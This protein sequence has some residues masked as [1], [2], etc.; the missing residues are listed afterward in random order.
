[1]AD[2]FFSALFFLAD[3]DFGLGEGLL[4]GFA[5]GV[6]W[7]SVSSS[8]SDSVELEGDFFFAGELFDFGV[9]D[10]SASDLE[11][12][13]FGRGVGV[14]FFFLA[15][16]V[17]VGV[18]DLWAARWS[19]FGFGESSSLTSPG[20]MEATSALSAKA[21]AMQRRKRATSTAP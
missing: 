7:R 15:V 1:L 20:K 9:S 6:G 19:G 21:V 12:V 11:G 5:E 16:A 3:L 18:G 4:D 14:F 10:S 2:F 17:G 8:S 13:F